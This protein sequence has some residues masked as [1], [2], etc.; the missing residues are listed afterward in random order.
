M[1]LIVSM[2][3]TDP[4]LG[5]Q[6]PRRIEI[7]RR[8]SIGRGPEND[9]VLPDPARVLSK[10]HCVIEAGSGG[11]VIVDCSTNGVFLNNSAERLPRD[12]PMPIQPGD[13]LQIGGYALEV[14]GFHQAAAPVDDFEAEFAPRAAPPVSAEPDPFDDLLG[15]FGSDSRSNSSRPAPGSAGDFT[16][17]DPPAFDDR[18]SDHRQPE[19]MPDFQSSR[20]ML[21]DNDDDLFGPSSSA[22]E[23]TGA[24]QPDHSAGTSAF[25]APPK[26]SS[27]G[28]PDDWDD[29]LDFAPPGAAA[30]QAPAAPK[31]V[32]P[33][34]EDEPFPAP[35]PPAVA[36]VPPLP[37]RNAFDEPSDR[38][39]AAPVA[40]PVPRAVPVATDADRGA[41]AALLQTVGIT[42]VSLDD[43]ESVAL[44]ERVGRML[45]VLVPG[46]I[47][48]LAARGSTKQEFHIERTMLG[49]HDNNPLK[50]AG[51]ADEA[52][53][54]MLLQHVPGFLAID[55]A[56]DQAV[57]DIKT[58]QLAVLAGMQV[59]LKTVIGRFEPGQL[60]ARLERS[61]LL[62]GILPG[63]RKARYWDLF[64]TLH[65]E[66]VRELQD[67]LQK[68]FGADF[69]EA[70]RTQIDRLAGG[71]EGG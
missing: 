44:M 18:M 38:A 64:K 53:R 11:Y 41:V 45:S 59:A 21:P 7:D 29:L 8:L 22:E 16:P 12:V 70:Y 32:V 46:L 31:V 9:L 65:S 24:S 13:L 37:E 6:S 17:F 60:E 48:I 14:T 71:G 15:D 5:T 55:Q 69:A 43:A 19:S 28:I 47:E 34:Q 68:L 67:D 36:P 56:V 2:Q 57:S 4:A 63:A 52:M 33:E 62:D 40:R 30:P 50:F 35:S 3:T 27:P 25:F 23:W 58:H 39:S 10:S 42:G 20:P 51:S 26:V 54:V 1:P 49:A 66:I 61:S